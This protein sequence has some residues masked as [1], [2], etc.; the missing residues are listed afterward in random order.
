MRSKFLNRSAVISTLA[1]LCLVSSPHR[2]QAQVEFISADTTAQVAT[3][4]GFDR[5]S[6]VTELVAPGQFRNSAFAEVKQNSQGNGAGL[7][8]SEVRVSTLDQPTTL[9]AFM[10]VTASTLPQFNSGTFSEAHVTYFFTTPTEVSVRRGISQGDTRFFIDL[11]RRNLTGPTTRFNV[12]PGLHT[13]EIEVVPGAVVVNPNLSVTLF[14][15]SSQQPN[16]TPTPTPTATSTPEQLTPTVAIKVSVS[17]MLADIRK[18]SPT[19]NKKNKGT[20][21]ALIT[22]IRQ[23]NASIIASLQPLLPTISQPVRVA[24]TAAS[25][26]VRRAISNF[27]SAGSNSRSRAAAKAGLLSAARRLDKLVAG[28]P[29]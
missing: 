19:V 5:K 21:A 17:N 1:M 20:Q 24:I 25:K 29:G 7:A 3:T 27:R 28:L 26:S 18:L 10:Q 12:E 14:A 6:G 2:A 8:T 15:I 13:F 22:L 4:A 16:A 11:V 9:D 23:Q